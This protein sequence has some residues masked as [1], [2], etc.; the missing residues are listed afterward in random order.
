MSDLYAYRTA[1]LCDAR[2]ASVRVAMPILRDFGGLSCFAGQIAT[3]RTY[4]DNALV[5][6]ALE[7]PGRSR[8]LVID[9]GGSARCAL[10]GDRLARLGADNG[11]AGL[12]VHGYVR[13]T[14]ALAGIPIGVK[15]LGAH[16]MRSAKRGAGEREVALTFAS[17]TFSPGQYLY[18]DADGVVVTEQPWDG[19]V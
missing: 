5:R 13:D 18:A 4:E 2:A 8:V 6:Q 3:V 12:V 1:D 14:A 7:E 15:A 16:P 19:A 17:V 9:G 10:V 11:W